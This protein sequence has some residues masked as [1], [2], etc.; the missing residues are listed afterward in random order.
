MRTTH[1]PSAS[2]TPALRMSSSFDSPVSA[3]LQ[4][5]GIS[6]VHDER[7]ESVTY[8]PAARQPSLNLVATNLKRS[9]RPIHSRHLDIGTVEIE[10][11]TAS[12]GGLEELDRFEPI[13]GLLEIDA[14]EDGPASQQRGGSMRR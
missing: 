8:D 6:E 5:E 4:H 14:L 7:A 10:G 2:M 11:L 12:I 3:I 1:G 13:L 9:F